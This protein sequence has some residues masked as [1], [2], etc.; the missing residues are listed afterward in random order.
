MEAIGREQRK[1]MDDLNA[2][3]YMDSAFPLLNAMTRNNA[4][5]LFERVMISHIGRNR[6]P[7]LGHSHSRLIDQVGENVLRFYYTLRGYSEAFA[8]VRST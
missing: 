6:K 2:R 4:W 8:G 7:W 5:G 1:L 3:G